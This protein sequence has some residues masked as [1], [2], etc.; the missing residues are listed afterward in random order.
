VGA[1]I[2]N[3]GPAV[4]LFATLGLVALARRD[5]ASAVFLG[6][7]AIAP[8]ILVVLLGAFLDARQDYVFAC[9]P[10]AF[11]LAGSFLAETFRSAP[12]LVG[13]ALVSLA[14][15]LVAPS[16]ASHYGDGNRHDVRAAGEYLRRHA[17]K[18]DFVVGEG[19]ALLE[20]YSGRRGILESPPTKDELEGFA[21]MAR[22]GVPVWFVLFYARNG[23]MVDGSSDLDA[24][25]HEN[26][27]LAT[28][29]L[30]P[31]FDYHENTIRIWRIDPESVDRG[32]SGANANAS[33]VA[34]GGR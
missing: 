22:R 31:R 10:F 12:R 7:A 16:I 32:G 9:A 34:G 11:L 26:A 23:L 13:V 21:E 20:S 30:H 28:E 19:H 6:L 27:R 24:F 17:E 5:R 33:S 29:I 15:L 2:L 25:V 1:V 4:V 18:T 8:P 14:L 3:L